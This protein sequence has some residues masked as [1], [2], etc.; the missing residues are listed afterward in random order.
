MLGREPTLFDMGPDI[1]PSGS[2][3]AGVGEILCPG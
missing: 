1:F 2:K 3:G